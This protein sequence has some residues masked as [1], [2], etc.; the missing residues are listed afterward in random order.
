MKQLFS[1]TW[2]CVKG[3][4]ETSLKKRQLLVKAL[5]L[6]QVNTEM[7]CTYLVLVKSI[8]LSTCIR[9]VIGVKQYLLN[10]WLLNFVFKMKIN[11]NLLFCAFMVH[12]SV[13]RSF[14]LLC[15]T[16]QTE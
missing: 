6:I 12:N 5:R 8:Y 13:A 16:F 7:S 10:I 11:A 14:S 1:T 2:K 3:N 15:I 4:L 9:D